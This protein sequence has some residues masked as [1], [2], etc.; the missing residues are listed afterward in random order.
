MRK[1][2]IIFLILKFSNSF[3]Q[4][5]IGLPN[6]FKDSAYTHVKHLESF[7]IR[8]AAL[9]GETETMR[10]IDDYFL[11]LNL[12]TVTDTFDFLCY[13]AKEIDLYIENSKLEYKDIY[14]NPYEDSTEINGN[15]YLFFNANQDYDSLTQN[16]VN[17]KIIITKEPVNK[18]I[19][20]KY[21]PKAI[22]ILDE[23]E[24]ANFSKKIKKC[25]IKI[26]GNLNKYKSFNIYSSID[27]L[28]KKDIIIGA[29]WDSYNGPGADDNASGVS[30]VLELARYF[31]NHKNELPFNIKF[32]FFG[33]EEFGLLG[34]KAYTQKHITDTS[35]TIYYLNVDCVGDT[36]K[37]IADI[38]SDGYR[39]QI[40][41]YVYPNKIDK[42][43]S[44]D[45]SS[46]WYLID[47]FG[48]P[49]ASKVPLWLQEILIN[50]LDSSNHD[51]YKANGI[52]S[53]HNSFSLM[54]FNAIHIGMGGNNTQHCPEDKISQVNKESLELVG[55]IIA[56]TVMKT[57]EKYKNNY[58]R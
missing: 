24:F 9:K 55:K 13:E 49:D 45:F 48:I 19:L 5:L 42:M 27:I 18:Y 35:S 17:N 37:I 52:G 14:I 31:N 12:K 30:V 15:V 47:L 58:A 7:G 11:S 40:E 8:N 20:Y 6:G 23:K 41:N 34:S 50:V 46:H 39:H 53:D 22:I 36:G 38:N 44:K 33:A 56:T 10:Y 2:I 51:Y 29:H 1:L 28:R 43:A 25:T 21:K 4:G 54:G 3:G 16:T 32:V 26:Q 57:A